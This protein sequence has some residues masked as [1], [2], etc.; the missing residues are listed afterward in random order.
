MIGMFILV[1]F[2]F[3][4]ISLWSFVISVDA[5]KKAIRGQAALEDS[6]QL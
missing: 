2:D 1:W 6:K 4:L 3:S 5:W